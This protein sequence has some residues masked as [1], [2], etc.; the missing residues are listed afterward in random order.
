V[1]EIIR[2]RGSD[3]Y[4]Q[5]AE[6]PLVKYTDYQTL[7]AEVER[8]NNIIEH[9]YEYSHEDVEPIDGALA[10]VRD[11]QAEVERF[12]HMLDHWV[13]QVD[14]PTVYKE[15]QEIREQRVKVKSEGGKS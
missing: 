15:M 13:C 12:H 14:H 7:Q 4:A 5:D 6:G 1:S 3:G 8:L 11:L 9:V 2:Y 10:E